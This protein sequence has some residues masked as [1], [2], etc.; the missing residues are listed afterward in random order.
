MYFKLLFCW[1][2]VLEV[3][4]NEG[5]GLKKDVLIKEYENIMECN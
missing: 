1:I 2:Y 3:M 5:V 4:C